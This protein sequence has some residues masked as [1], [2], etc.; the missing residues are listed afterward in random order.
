MESFESIIASVFEAMQRE[1]KIYNNY[2]SQN[3]MEKGNRFVQVMQ[4]AEDE[5]KNSI[6]ELFEQNLPY[7]QPYMAVWW[8][9]VLIG[10]KNDEQIFHRFLQYIQSH[11][12]AF[13]ANT[14]YFL[15][16]QLMHQ[17]FL[18][19]TLDT[20]ENKIILWQFYNSIIDEFAKN[21]NTP[22]DEIPK[23]QRDANFVLVITEQFLVVQHGPTKTALD[24]CKAL[25]SRQKKVL[26]IN[27]AEVLSSVGMIPYYGIY[28]GNNNPNMLS[29]KMQT[30]KGAAI[31]YYQCEDNMPDLDTLDDL[32]SDVRK[33]A[34]GR[35]VLIGKGG[36]FGNLVSRMVPTL[37]IGLCPS[38]LEYTTAKYQLLGRKINSEDIE[39]L[40]RVGLN[41]NHV[42]EGCFTSSLLLQTQHTTREQL[43]LP[44]EDFLLVVV[45]ARLDLEVSDEFLAM[46]EK[47]FTDKMFL[48]FCGIYEQ[49]E[50]QIQKY[51]KLKSQSAKLGYCD[52]IL[53]KLEVCDLY[54][55]PT[56][57]G[58]GTSSVEALYMGI[59]VVT[60]DFGDVS[61]NVGEEFCVQD[62]EEMQDKIMQYHDD[63]AYYEQM[64]KKAKAR[65]DILLDTET[66]FIRVLQEMDRREAETG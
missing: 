64:S 32:L 36:V 1:N 60:V 47:I 25:I 12:M 48:V 9:S 28:A 43:G 55:N 62:Y 13:S 4:E 27:D 24:R 11:R 37:T 14:Q 10:T 59:P 22:L 65:A 31:P 29:E 51:P 33:M 2:V 57:R 66:E 44:K 19:K 39:Q 6:L 45:G 34:P 21:M 38:A 49:Y 41:K 42:I 58:G 50:A 26:L 54:V 7:E 5:V 16:Y 8:Y 52:D 3:A 35:V 17:M 63:K 61:T 46:M 23:E 15:W 40:Q 53:S 20:Q 30:W 56:R 18:I